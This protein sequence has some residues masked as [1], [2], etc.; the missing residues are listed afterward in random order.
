MYLL[1]VSLRKM[2]GSD[3]KWRGKS[4]RIPCIERCDI[5]CKKLRI[6]ES[7]N[8]PESVCLQSMQYILKDT[9]IQYPFWSIYLN[10][11]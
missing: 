11:L 1:I 4:G 10:D 5:L 2:Y 8:V 6:Q 7:I 3:I 9:V